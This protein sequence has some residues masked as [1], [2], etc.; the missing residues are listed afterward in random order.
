[1][2]LYP[3]SPKQQL[4]KLKENYNSLIGRPNMPAPGCNGLYQRYAYPVLTDMHIPL[5]W[6]YDFSE[7]CNPYMLQRI[8]V[9]AVFNAGAILHKG[10]YLLA[11]R[12]EGCD[13]KS[14]F[15]IAESPDGISSFRFWEKPILMP[16]GPNPD[17]NVYDMRLTRHQDGWIY[18]IFCTE[19][20]DPTSPPA[21]TSSAAAAAGIARTKDLIKWE[22]LPDLQSGGSQQRN[23]VLHQELIGGRYMFYTRPQDGFI[24]AGN[25]GGICVGFVRDIANPVLEEE[26]AIFPR[27]YHTVYEEKNGMGPAPIKTSKGWLHLGHGV[28]SCAAGLRYVLY[29]FLCDI[30]D[31]SRVIA[32]PGGYFMAP[33]GD[34]RVGDVSNVLFSNGWICDEKGR[35]LIYYASSDT[36]LHVAE[37]SVERMLD[38]CIN[39]PAD[40]LATG[41]SV[42]NII[43]LI[44]KNKA[45]G[46]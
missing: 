11:A 3:I 1:M 38:Y 43:K 42:Q 27:Q 40:G 45:I 20:K 10:K 41:K 36:R 7:T 19:R 25:G 26:R 31:P 28:R 44:D 39:T 21:D 8:G 17:I 35:I 5:E 22:R 13:R 37:T 32:K 18:G 30:A 9:N 15:A 24:E 34:E 14:Y 29:A 6:K 46:K 33:R 23:V 12:V 2:E 16:E 4:D